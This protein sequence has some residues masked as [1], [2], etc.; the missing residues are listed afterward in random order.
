VCHCGRSLPPD[1]LLLDELLLD[2]LFVPLELEE[3]KLSTLIVGPPG[4]VKS[5]PSKPETLTN[6]AANKDASLAV[7]AAIPTKVRLFMQITTGICP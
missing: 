7:R 3:W 2:E 1:E 5:L 6:K 4:I